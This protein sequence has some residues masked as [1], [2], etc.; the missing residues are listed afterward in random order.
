MDEQ[1]NVTQKLRGYHTSMYE[2]F[3]KGKPTEI[4]Y[5][6]GYVCREGVRSNVATPVN[7]TDILVKA[8]IFRHKPLVD[9]S[10]LF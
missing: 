4:D 3:S 9:T 1:I 6:N 7:Y 5:F 8:I 2:D 10:T